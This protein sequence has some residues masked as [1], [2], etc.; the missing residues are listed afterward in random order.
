[1][2]RRGRCGIGKCEDVLPERIAVVQSSLYKGKIMDE[3][4][5]YSFRDAAFVGVRLAAILLFLG[6]CASIRITDPAH[7]ATEQFLLSHAA[8]EAVKPFSFEVL[9]GRKIYVD[10]TYFAA[11]QK[12]FVLGE[13]RAKLLLAGVQILTKRDAC[14]IV[15]EIRSGGVGIDR[16]ESLLGIPAIGAAA[17]TAATGAGVPVTGII[18][19]EIAIT[20]EIKQI[21]YASV[22]Y[23]AYW[24]DTGEVVDS[25]GPSVGKVYRDDWWLF[26][27]GPRTIGTIPP[28]DHSID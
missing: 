19:P 10:D 26:G 20:K 2:R 15:L 27:F 1:M 21:G 16:Y 28:V 7:T 12:E 13:L 18:T 4:K 8:I 17:S 24:S 3:N 22:A 9:R 23:V 6:G 5:M 11:S 14:E 25:A